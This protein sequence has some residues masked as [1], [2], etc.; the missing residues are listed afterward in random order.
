MSLIEAQQLIE[1]ENVAASQRML[2]ALDHINSPPGLPTLFLSADFPDDDPALP[3]LLLTLPLDLAFLG[4]AASSPLS[5]SLAVVADSPAPPVID[6]TLHN[7]VPAQAK[8]PRAPSSPAAEEPS[9]SSS[10]STVAGT[11]TA[12]GAP[13]PPPCATEDGAEPLGA[14]ERAVRARAL[15][16][17]AIARFRAKKA[18]NRLKPKRR[19]IRYDCR[20]V[21]AHKRPRVRG[22]F[23]RLEAGAPE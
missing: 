20:K 2:A 4:E 19:L 10:S 13:S 9:S 1:A 21:L 15:R 7:A 6:L 8:R 22:R 5:P 17:D 16:S 23:V 12:A 18:A 3:G 14:V 11:V